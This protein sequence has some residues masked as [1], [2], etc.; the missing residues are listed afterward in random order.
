[1][2]FHPDRRSVLAGLT[3]VGLTAAHSPQA[4]A[5][6]VRAPRIAV[7]NDDFDL[8]DTALMSGPER[9]AA[10][11]AALMRHRVKAGGFVAGKYVDK[12]LSPRILSAWSDGGHIIG[13]HSFSH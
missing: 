7:T 9:D 13:N 1:M 4:S 8:S 10:I 2:T 11:R 6:G 12:V 3:A 5:R